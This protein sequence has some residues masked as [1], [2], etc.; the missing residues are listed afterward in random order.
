MLRISQHL[1]RDTHSLWKLR[2][3]DP[4]QKLLKMA[5]KGFINNPWT[6]NLQ[7]GGCEFL[8]IFTCKPISMFL[9]GSSGPLGFITFSKESETNSLKTTLEVRC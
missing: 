1:F 8:D 7:I 2:N 4:R 6:D 5:E 3:P 9:G